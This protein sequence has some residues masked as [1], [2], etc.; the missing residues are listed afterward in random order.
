MPMG[1][2]SKFRYPKIVQPGSGHR[3]WWLLGLVLVSLSAWW[4]LSYEQWCPEPDMTAADE[5]VALLGRQ[6]AEFE[7]ERTELRLEVARLARANQIDQ[8]AALGLREEIRTLQDERLKLEQDVVFLRRVVSHG[9]GKEVLRIKDFKLVGG[10]EEEKTRYRFVV[11]LAQERSSAVDG[12]I[13][14]SL[15]GVQD[16]KTKILSLKTLSSGKIEFVKM[17]F[18]RFQSIDGLM[19]FP[20]NFTPTRVLV[21]IQP[22]DEEIPPLTKAFD[23]VI[24]G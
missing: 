17:R 12:K 4:S 15:E 13:L 2:G 23:W 21:D 1:N 24:K 11:S 9:A 7:G 3:Y 18:K 22:N 8:E 20:K 6:V 10:A 16:G 19:Q 5:E 14:I